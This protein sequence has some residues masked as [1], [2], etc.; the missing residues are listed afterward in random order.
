[1]TTK[2]PR[3]ESTKE[4]RMAMIV[5]DHEAA[6]TMER[7]AIAL[8]KGVDRALIAELTT[9]HDTMEGALMGCDGYIYPADGSALRQYVEANGYRMRT[10]EIRFFYF[11]YKCKS[12]WIP[13][14]A[15]DPPVTVA[16]L[17]HFLHPHEAE[18]LTLTA[19]GIPLAWKDRLPC[20]AL[21]R[22]AVL[23]DPMVLRVCTD[24]GQ[25]ADGQE[26]CYGECSRPMCKH[27]WHPPRPSSPDYS[28]QSRF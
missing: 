25:Q 17:L 6:R 16:R 22:T 21:L 14:L 15:G 10:R 18:E 7:R 12:Y 11:T 20:N 27:Y 4:E 19:D 5:R 8:M 2:R 26:P 24:P 9:G 3:E 1:M 23:E 13:V 28:V